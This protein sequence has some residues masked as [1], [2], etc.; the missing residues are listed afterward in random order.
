MSITRKDDLNQY[1]VKDT[2]EE[3][4]G[5][6]LILDGLN[7]E[8]GVVTEFV[9]PFLREHPEINMVSI[10]NNNLTEKSIEALATLTT[11]MY[12]FLRGNNFGATGAMMLAQNP[13]FRSLALDDNHIGD[14]GLVAFRDNTTLESLNANR[15]LITDVG[16]EAIAKNTSLTFVSLTG[17]EGITEK[18]VALLDQNTKI[19][20]RFIDGFP[21]SPSSQKAETRVE[22]DDESAAIVTQSPAF[23]RRDPI[24]AAAVEGLVPVLSRPAESDQSTLAS[25]PVSAKPSAKVA[26]PAQ[27]KGLTPTY[28]T[29]EKLLD[30]L[31]LLKLP[32]YVNFVQRLDLTYLTRILLNGRYFQEAL[33]QEAVYL[34]DEDR[35]R[36]MLLAF[37]TLYLKRLTERTSS[38]ASFTGW[39]TGKPSK[40]DK[41]PAAEK[42]HELLASGK[43]LEEVD[44]E[45]ETLKEYKAAFNDTSMVGYRVGDLTALRRQL[46]VMLDTANR[47]TATVV[48]SMV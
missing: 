27:A 30:A 31:S 42:Y 18:G 12:L 38:H 46:K 23:S 35:S 43:S 11:V 5:A 20:R 3:S 48:K 10:N 28:E 25:S 8:D 47:K 19:A 34:N 16:V 14:A 2:G 29:A 13:Y 17:N 15:C 36:R 21:T 7:V 40:S 4:A 22:L 9:A 6:T 33:T 24:P 41:Q 26:E 44:A 1:Y 39:L 45:L 32:Q 37:L